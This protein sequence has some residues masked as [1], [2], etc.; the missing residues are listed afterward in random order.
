MFGNS[1]IDFGKLN[2][3]WLSSVSIQLDEIAN[4]ILVTE[5]AQ[6]Y[7]REGGRTEVV[8]YTNYR[9]FIA[10][11]FTNTEH[12]IVVEDVELPSYETIQDVILRR[13][14]EETE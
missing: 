13:L 10:V 2:L 7:L 4:L 8:G 9:K 3:S 1:E 14:A 5:R 11:I 6:T 12:K